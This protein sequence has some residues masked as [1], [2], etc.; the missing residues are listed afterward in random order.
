MFLTYLKLNKDD[1]L[2]DIDLSSLFSCADDLDIN[3]GISKY[4]NITQDIC[5]KHASGMYIYK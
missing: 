2:N 4:T 3:M 1:F 5:D